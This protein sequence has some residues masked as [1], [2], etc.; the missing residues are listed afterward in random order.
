[1]RHNKV[2]RAAAA[3]QLIVRGPALTGRDIGRLDFYFSN[4][5][6]IGRTQARNGRNEAVFHGVAQDLRSE[7]API[8]VLTNCVSENPLELIR[9]MWQFVSQH[10]L[11]TT[12]F[13]TILQKLAVTAAPQSLHWPESHVCGHDRPEARKTSSQTTAA[14][15]SDPHA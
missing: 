2:S 4:L 10:T 15:H 8:S 13:T 1:M 12:P 9:R 7:K 11:G 3:K 14:D 5:R 6:P